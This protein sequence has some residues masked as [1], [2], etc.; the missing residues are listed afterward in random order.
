ML[1]LQATC[2][3][4]DLGLAWRIHRGLLFDLV[5]AITKL[6]YI[7][8]ACGGYVNICSFLWEA[9]TIFGGLEAKPLRFEIG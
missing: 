2:G 8:F 3:A 5:I 1:K 9:M 6:N 7:V 4:Q